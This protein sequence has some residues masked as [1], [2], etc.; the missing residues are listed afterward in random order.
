LSVG[1]VSDDSQ[2]PPSCRLTIPGSPRPPHSSRRSDSRP[3]SPRAGAGHANSTPHQ[4]KPYVPEFDGPTR[5]RSGWVASAPGKVE[6]TRSDGRFA[7][8]RPAP[9]SVPR[10]A[11]GP[12]QRARLFVRRFQ[13][14]CTQYRSSPLYR[15]R[16]R[17]VAYSG[18]H[19]SFAH[20]M[21]GVTERISSGRICPLCRSLNRIV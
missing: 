21:T 5:V 11:P 13:G 6:T 12:A 9:V 8:D 18:L 19:L 2:A 10:A 17:K 1:G 3:P 20:T 14:A 15:L 4:F 16:G 7:S